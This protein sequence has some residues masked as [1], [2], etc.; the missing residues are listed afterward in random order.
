[1]MSADDEPQSNGSNIL[2]SLPPSNNLINEAFNLKPLSNSIG[3]LPPTSSHFKPIQTETKVETPAPVSALF[4]E[5]KTSFFDSPQVIT[6]VATKA[7]TPPNTSS[8]FNSTQPLNLAPITANLL[9][10]SLIPP[11]STIPPSAIIP[12]PNATGS[13][14]YS[15]KGALNKKVY[16]TGISVLPINQ[17]QTFLKP[18]TDQTLPNSGLFIPPSTPSPS[19]SLPPTP[20][21]LLQPSPLNVQNKNVQPPTITPIFPI[22]NQNIPPLA[23]SVSVPFQQPSISL[24][25]RTPGLDKQASQNYP[26]QQQKKPWGWFSNVV[27]KVV[28]TIDPQM[29]DYIHPANK[30]IYLVS[31]MSNPK[32]VHIVR[33]AFC[34]A[35]FSKITMNGIEAQN[36]TQFAPQIVGYPCAIQSAKEKLENTLYSMQNI[37]C[38]VVSFQDFITELTSDNWYELAVVMLKDKQNQIEITVFTEATPVS[39]DDVAQLQQFT[40]E[41]YSLKW[42]GLSCRLAEK[43]FN[44][45]QAQTC[46]FLNYETP[47]TIISTGRLHHALKTLALLYKNKLLSMMNNK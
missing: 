23:P 29:K 1:M 30:Q 12:P 44:F 31:S 28:T 26:Q 10:P 47:E 32:I 6:P 16:D 20:I 43:N 37:D 33:E 17:N 40:P 42:S 24:N 19:T 22:Q 36:N 25:E 5:T 11:P 7:P 35:G 2:T 41:D 27:E 45:N 39:S 8:I 13:N 38:I 14:P 34:D 15:A 9:P 18:V 4:A 46:T 3:I 21:P